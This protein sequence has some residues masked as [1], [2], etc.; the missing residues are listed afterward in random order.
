MMDMGF[1]PQ[2]RRILE[3]IPRKRQN[4]LFSATMPE[5]VTQLSEEFLEFPVR[6][7][8]SPPART[9]STVTQTLYQVPNLLTKINLLHFLLHRDADTMTRVLLF[10]RTKETPTRLLIFWSARLPWARCA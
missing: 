8:V 3:V 2:I 1:M 6:V 10:A 9:A 4:V 5:R 7:E